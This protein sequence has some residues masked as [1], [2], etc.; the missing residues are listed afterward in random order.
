M[1]KELF[2][3]KNVQSV[4]SGLRERNHR[5]HFSHAFVGPFE[6]IRGQFFCLMAVCNAFIESRR[7]SIIQN[8]SL[9][10]ATYL[11]LFSTI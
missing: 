1:I 10:V 4:E 8:V 2:T 7:R 6:G 11:T 3:Y 5:R 9:W